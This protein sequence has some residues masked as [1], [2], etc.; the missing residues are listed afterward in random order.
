MTEANPRWEVREDSRL[1][2]YKYYTRISRTR[3]STISS[4]IRGRELE[5]KSRNQRTRNNFMA[6]NTG[7]VVQ[8]VVRA[9]IT[10]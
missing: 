4:L 6:N 8:C 10:S 7:H 2:M 1:A 3:V 9:F 5:G